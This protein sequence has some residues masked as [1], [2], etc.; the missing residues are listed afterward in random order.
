MAGRPSGWPPRLARPPRLFPARRPPL[1]R[2]PLV[3]A[4]PLPRAGAL[5]LP[6]GLSRLPVACG[7]SPAARLLR[8]P[9]L[10]RPPPLPPAAAALRLPLGAGGPRRGPGGRRHR[11]DPGRAVRPVPLIPA[12][13][14]Q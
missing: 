14:R 9:L 3:P 6:A 13:F 2:L 11:P 4:V 8:P 5:R 1:A 10:R 7:P 12:V